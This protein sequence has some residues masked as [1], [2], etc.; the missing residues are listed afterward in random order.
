M[1]E[2][3]TAGSI[4]LSGYVRPKTRGELRDLLLAGVPCEVASHVAEMTTVML[5]GWLGVSK[6]SVRPSENAG[7]SVFEALTI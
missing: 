2:A 3:Q 7:W 5:Q 6:F 1:A 4:N